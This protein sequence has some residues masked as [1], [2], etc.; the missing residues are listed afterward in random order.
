MWVLHACVPFLKWKIKTLLHDFCFRESLDE[1]NHSSMEISCLEVFRFLIL[2]RSCDLA[3]VLPSIIPWIRYL[4]RA[5]HRITYFFLALVTLSIKLWRLKIPSSQIFL[6]TCVWGN[7]YTYVKYYVWHST[8]IMLINFKNNN[9]RI[10]TNNNY[11][12][13]VLQSRQPPTL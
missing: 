6:G 5:Q 12:C 2:V 11:S 9:S 10:T 1:S 4:F 3:S 8:C 7:V 13:F